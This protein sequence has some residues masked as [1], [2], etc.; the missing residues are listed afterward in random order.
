MHARPIVIE[1]SPRSYRLLEKAAHD[2]GK[3]PEV[4]SR[5]ILE[6]A[7]QR[8]E[9]GTQPKREAVRQVLRAA[10]RIHTLSPTLRH[11]II[12][13]VT[14]EEVQESLAHAGGKPLSEIILEQRGSRP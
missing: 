11:R 1:L 9:T 2:T 4:L 7:L 6:E 10:G 3:A 13:G 5:E 12:P 8:T 14:L